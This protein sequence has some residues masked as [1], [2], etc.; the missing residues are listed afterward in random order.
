M[1]RPCRK[2]MVIIIAS[3]TLNLV[4]NQSNITNSTGRVD[5][6][7]THHEE[8]EKK[9]EP[10]R[11]RDEVKTAYTFGTFLGRNWLKSVNPKLTTSL[12]IDYALQGAPSRRR[13]RCAS[14]DSLNKASI[15]CDGGA[16]SVLSVRNG[17]EELTRRS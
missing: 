5:V 1:P 4:A 7:P 11:P 17:F 2:L 8:R 16:A 12:I 6:S 14:H 9:N 13:L 10:E 3:R 15:V